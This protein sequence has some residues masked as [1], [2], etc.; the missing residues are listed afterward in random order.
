MISYKQKKFAVSLAWNVFGMS[1]AFAL[2]AIGK[3]LGIFDLSPEMTAFVGLII[4]RLT[5][6]ANIYFQEKA[7]DNEM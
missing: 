4:S 3:N 5:K 7:A 2:D 6:V 1:L